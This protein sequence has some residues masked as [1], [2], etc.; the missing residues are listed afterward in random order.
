MAENKL[1]PLYVKTAAE[2]LL[3]NYFLARFEQKKYLSDRRS[4][5]V[6]QLNNT[7]HLK[8]QFDQC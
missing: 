3:Q 4:S 7:R 5:R 1:T 2:I 8:K 6:R